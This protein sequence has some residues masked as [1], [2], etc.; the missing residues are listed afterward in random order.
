[1]RGD[2]EKEMRHGRG[3]R[4]ELGFHPDLRGKWEEEEGIALW[5]RVSRGGGDALAY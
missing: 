1:M 3:S 4:F 2:R 5:A